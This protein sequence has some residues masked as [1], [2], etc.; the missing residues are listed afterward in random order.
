MTLPG[1]AARLARLDGAA[2]ALLARPGVAA[3]TAAALAGI[4]P[5]P[6]LEIPMVKM[7][8][9]SLRLS[10]EQEARADALIPAFAADPNLSAFGEITRSTVLR[11]AL[12][13]GL[14]ALEAEYTPNRAPGKG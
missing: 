7:K 12:H 1:R 4:L 6:D 10:P 3:R 14:L 11:V 5:S 13:R 2:T 9:T 8:S